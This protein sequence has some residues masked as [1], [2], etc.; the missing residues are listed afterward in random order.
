MKYWTEQGKYQAEADQLQTLLPPAGACATH[1]GE[2]WRAATKIYYDYFN[3]GFGNDWREPAAFLI[4]SVTL[5]Q[6]I[7]DILYDHAAGN[8]ADAYDKEMDLM[9]DQVIEHLR[10]VEDRPNTTDMWETKLTWEQEQKFW[11]EETY[12]DRFDY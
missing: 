7:Y 8:T 10:T 5:S 4:N 2:I 3:N 1:K 9:I 12:D 11:K 6:E